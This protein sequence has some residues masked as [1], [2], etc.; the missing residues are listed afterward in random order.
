M[1]ERRVSPGRKGGEPGRSVGRAGVVA[2][3]VKSRREQG[4][5][6]ESEVL[7]MDTE[8]IWVDPEIDTGV[9]RVE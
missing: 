6:V 9:T 5:W 8:L 2:G 4:T 1:N 3:P 7:E